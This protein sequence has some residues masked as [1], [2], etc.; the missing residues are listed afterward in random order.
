MA[1]PAKDMNN[2]VVKSLKELLTKHVAINE[3]ENYDYTKVII[4]LRDF[5]EGTDLQNAATFDYHEYSMSEIVDI[6]SL[7]ILVTHSGGTTIRLIPWSAVSS[8][9][10]KSY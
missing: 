2:D 9:Y 5:I 4:H 7:G 8:L 3:L 1:N 6:D 10:I